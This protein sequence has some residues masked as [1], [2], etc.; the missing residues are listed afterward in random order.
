MTFYVKL[1]TS[2]TD[3]SIRLEKAVTLPEPPR[4][5]QRLRGHFDRAVLIVVAVRLD[6][7]GNLEADVAFSLL[8]TVPLEAIEALA[9]R[10]NWVVHDS[11]SDTATVVDVAVPHSLASQAAARLAEVR[12][13]EPTTAV[14]HRDTLRE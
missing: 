3:E 7:A 2:N 8:D 12:D 13:R 1:R 5:G 14:T 11:S 10:S 9:K 6:G 4:V